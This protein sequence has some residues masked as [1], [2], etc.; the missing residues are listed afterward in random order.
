MI[1]LQFKIE[2]MSNR[3]LERRKRGFLGEDFKLESWDLVQPFYENLKN[4]R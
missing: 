3:I 2:I 4:E 1:K